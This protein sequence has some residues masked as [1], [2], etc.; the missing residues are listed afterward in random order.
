MPLAV[1]NVYRHLLCAGHLLLFSVMTGD[2]VASVASSSPS[3]TQGHFRT[4]AHSAGVNDG[5]DRRNYP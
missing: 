2:T 3:P 5:S 1:V 4:Q